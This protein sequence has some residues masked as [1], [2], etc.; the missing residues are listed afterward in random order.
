A[1][2][3]TWTRSCSRSSRT[4]YRSTSSRRT[5][6]PPTELE[7]AQRAGLPGPEDAHVDCGG[8]RRGHLG[9]GRRGA[10]RPARA[11]P[12]RVRPPVNRDRDVRADQLESLDSPHRVEMA[13]RQARSP[14]G[15][16][17]EG[18]VDVAELSHPLEEVGV[19][20]EVD[21]SC[22]GDDVADGEC[23]AGA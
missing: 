15:D 7:L 8:D 12:R 2:A 18:D 11:P 22:A 17:E 16:G 20:R 5:P 21:G 23:L 4:G 9:E 6:W 13:G 10:V 19:A 3:P 14:A 1:G